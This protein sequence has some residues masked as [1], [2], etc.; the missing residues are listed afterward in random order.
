MVRHRPLEKNDD[1]LS[2]SDISSTDDE[3]DLKPFRDDDGAEGAKSTA[4]L[5]RA[6]SRKSS[7]E[8][9]D[10]DGYAPAKG[11]EY[12]L[13]GGDLSSATESGDEERLV[14]MGSKGKGKG[15]KPKSRKRWVMRS[16]EKGTDT[17]PS[18]SKDPAAADP[19]RTSLSRTLAFAVL[20][21]GLVCSHKTEVE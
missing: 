12:S 16:G 4:S 10:S 17:G 7:S 1:F 18:D 3:H 15:K 11:G 5:P 14:G 13:G 19:V 8:S 20:I 2:E 21:V 6:S 9:S